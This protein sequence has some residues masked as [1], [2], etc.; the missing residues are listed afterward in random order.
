[1]VLGSTGHGPLGLGHTHTYRLLPSNLVP[2]PSSIHA[3]HIEGCH[4]LSHSSF[5]RGTPLV[6]LD[7][8]SE[9]CTHS[10]C[11]NELTNDK[12]FE[13]VYA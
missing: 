3:D 5:S 6:G 12:Y 4:K 8:V 1:M 9:P 10:S 13:T 11:K 2:T 7:F